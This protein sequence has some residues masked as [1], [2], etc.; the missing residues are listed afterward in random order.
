MTLTAYRPRC[1][2][3]GR[4]TRLPPKRRTCVGRRA[5]F[6]RR[7]RWQY[8]VDALRKYLYRQGIRDLQEVLT[9]NTR[10]LW[11]ASL[12]H[13]RRDAPIG[14]RSSV[15]ILM[16][17]PAAGRIQRTRRLNQGC[18]ACLAANANTRMPERAFQGQVLQLRQYN[19]KG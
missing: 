17:G 16:R 12:L 6:G 13:P 14:I 15:G 9:Y 19:G 2:V 8:S 4:A 18:G 11:R 1:L 5:S 3:E 10:W 7:P